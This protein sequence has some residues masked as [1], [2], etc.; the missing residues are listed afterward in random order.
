MPELLDSIQS[1]EQIRDFS[2]AQKTRLA[3]EIRERIIEQVSSTGGHLASNLGVV[4]LTIALLASFD[5][6]RDQ[7]VFDVGHQSYTWKI[8]TGRLDQFSTLRQKN[9][10]AG[11]PKRAESPYDFFDTGHSSTSISAALGIVRAK[12]LTGQQGR[13]IALIGD[14]ALTGGMAF[15]AMNDAGSSAARLIV[16][17]NDNQ[18]SIGKNVGSMSRHLET[19]RISR[20]YIKLKSTLEALLKHIPI[21]GW[22]ILRLLK[23]LKQLDR[24][25]LRRSGVLFEQ[26]GFSYY[27]PIDGHDL[28]DLQ[29]HLERIKEL[30]G[31]VLL[32]VVTQKGRGYRFAEHSPDLYHG[33]APF[34]VENGVCSVDNPHCS[35][36]SD[37]FGQT[38]LDKAMKDPSICAIS[39]A[40]TSGTGLKGFSESLPAR[41]F[42]VGIAE[43]HAMTLAAGL[44]AG[45]ARPVIALYSTFLQRAIDQLLHDVC[46]QNLPV[47]L[48]IDRAGIVGEDGET[49]QGIYDLNMLLSIP[50]LEILC[51][52][53]SGQLSR[54]VHYAFGCQHPVAI[55]YPRG[56]AR[57]LDLPEGTPGQTLVLRQSGAKLTLAVLG[58]MAETALAVA[59]Q[60]MAEGVTCDIVVIQRAKPFDLEPLLTSANQ[61]KRLLLAEEAVYPGS[62]GQQVLPTLL[63]KL[64]DCLWDHV[65]IRDEPLMQGSRAQLLADQSLDIVGLASRAKQLLGICF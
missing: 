30:E 14:G 60:L 28:K 32:H 48:G 34:E 21:I 50:N 17:L 44:A 13:V 22:G 3:E 15:E 20:R 53:D 58:T 31:P 42:D 7:I 12:E 55:R 23:R 52:A 8:L 49:H 65:A 5:F 11:F 57:S 2:L 40:M 56:A 63:S 59:E 27:G 54:S 36:Y 51:P 16:I 33:V 47:V 29:R 35:T 45:G 18:M 38:V 9:G 37:V 61:T 10:M 39:A 19:L 1:P 43:Q 41:F 24:M 4:E 26:L 25:I 6:R 46:L 62:L 64:P